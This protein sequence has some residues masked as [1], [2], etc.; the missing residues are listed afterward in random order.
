MD[1]H[2]RPRHE[3]SSLSYCTPAQSQYVCW[4]CFHVPVCLPTLR[5]S[6]AALSSA[7]RLKAYTT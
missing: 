3:L 7:I 1:A 6:T 2:T 4:A 5:F